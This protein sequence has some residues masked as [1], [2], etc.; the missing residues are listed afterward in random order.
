MMVASSRE[1]TVAGERHEVVTTEMF[2]GVARQVD[3]LFLSSD[4]WSARIVFTDCGPTEEDR[5][6]ETIS[7]APNP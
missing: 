1:V 6:L 5:F 4:S 3:A 2:E 7:L